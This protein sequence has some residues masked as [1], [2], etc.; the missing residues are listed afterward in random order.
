MLHKEFFSGR[1][2][3]DYHRES[4]EY[5]EGGKEQGH[6]CRNGLELNGVSVTGAFYFYLNFFKI[7]RLDN[8]GNAT[9][10]FPNFSY[11]DKETFEYFDLAKRKGLG[12]LLITGRG[13]GKSYKASAL[14][15][16][17]Y[18]F[19]KNTHSVVSASTSDYAD[20]LWFKIREGLN[21]LHPEIYHNRDISD[22]KDLII[23]GTIYK[24]EN[25]QRREKG[26]FSKIEKVV[27]DF[28]PGKNRGSRPDIHIFEE[29]GSWAPDKGRLIDCYNMS[30]ASWTRGSKQTCLPILIGTG[31]EMK[32]GGSRDAKEMFYNPEA[33]NLLKFDDTYGVN[34]GKPICYFIPAYK[35]YEGFYEVQ[36][37]VLAKEEHEQYGFKVGEKIGE[38]KISGANDDIGAKKFFERKRASL[39]NSERELEQNIQE[40]PFTPQEAFMTNSHSPFSILKNRLY[41][42]E[43]NDALTDKVKIGR[44]EMTGE[45]HPED[46]MPVVKFVEDKRG[47]FQILE[48][49]LLTPTGAYYKKLYTAGC[50]SYDQD[51]ARTS[52]SQGSIFIYKRFLNANTTSNLFV[53]QYT[54]R[55]EDKYEFYYNTL[56]L[57]LYYRSSM[58]VEHSNL[59]IFIYYEQKKYDFLLYD[60]P[61]VA[62]AD[63]KDSKVTNKKGLHMDDKTK[64]YC[65]DAYKKYCRENVHQFFFKDQVLDHVEF[66][67]DENRFDRTMASMLCIVQDNDMYAIMAHEQK[68]KVSTV[69][70]PIWQLN[71]RGIPELI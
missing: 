18:T 62:Y 51:E 54:D 59:G 37:D 26:Y 58:L 48:E 53:A 47:K 43:M 19:F 31:G 5:I 34:S 22:T 30:K 24:D 39:E 25:G 35:K 44:L 36:G 67:R 4:I 65:I 14:A 38:V 49:P 15:S 60:R 27:Y 42:L 1:E 55:P 29:I 23:S 12:L 33:F 10:D 6:R 63:T 32:S 56:L 68:Q 8:Q 16:W 50:D 66:N 57:N 9:L 61:R 71:E 2:I 7:N 28:K 46:N 41:E 70:W 17:R 69:K 11:V 21:S 52:E 45:I 20:K 64:T 13:E 40:F 3:P